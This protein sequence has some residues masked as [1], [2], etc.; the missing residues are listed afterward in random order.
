MQR[1]QS[2]GRS[3]AG[4]FLV[5]SLLLAVLAAGLVFRIVKR[6]QEQLNEAAKPSDTVDVVVAQRDL[7]MGLSIGDQ[8]VVLRQLPVGSVPEEGTYASLDDV[9]G[10]TPKERIL[11]N[12]A[13]RDERLARPAQ[14]I[15]LNAVVTPGKRAMTV[16]TNTEDAVAGLLQPGNY[17]D[18]IVTIK[19]EDPAAA[20][21]KWAT[22]TILQTIKVLAVGG[23]LS[24]S[25][26]DQTKT[27]TSTP[28]EDGKKRTTT[29]TA[30]QP[31]SQQDMM[32]RMKPSITLEVTPE[33][34][35]KLAL[36]VAQGD[37][38]VV[39][40]S[41]IDNF[42]YTDNGPITSR[43]L[44]G[45]PAGPPSPIDQPKT[46]KPPA[47]PENT[48]PSATVIVGS[49]RTDVKFNADGTS[50]ETTDKRKKNR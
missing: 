36:A 45:F 4:L 27:V 30:A 31:G 41:D 37:I 13:I 48:G 28:G 9:V 10:R 15:G 49:S 14:G 46:D 20:N 33:E 21:A 18:I 25:A 34:A 26:S 1:Q 47:Q 11:A 12:E 40:R 32:R 16:A 29:T 24:Q 5:G 17:V 50:T 6:S 8:D 38:H 3:R 35:E 7:Y 42:Q 44:I 23:S 2:P 43:A 22:D 39:L 19:P